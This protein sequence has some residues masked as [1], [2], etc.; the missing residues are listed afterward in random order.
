VKRRSSSRSAHLDVVFA[1]DGE[2]RQ[3][4]GKAEKV[5]NLFAK[6]HQFQVAANRAGRHVQTNQR[7][8]ARA[9][10]V[11]KLFKVQHD[12]LGIRSVA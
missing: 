4:I 8:E 11:G 2:Y 10:H 3:E 12:S 9:V 5:A 7:A 1:D 6:M